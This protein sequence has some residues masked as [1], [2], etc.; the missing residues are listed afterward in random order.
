MVPLRRGGSVR[1]SKRGALE[2]MSV[3]SLSPS[4]SLSRLS[5]AHTHT[6]IHT[7]NRLIDGELCSLRYE[8]PV[9]VSVSQVIPH[10]PSPSV[11]GPAGL[12]GPGP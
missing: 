4:G 1:M 7:T 3:V 11:R 5:A 9:Q 8:E 12:S 2:Q 6:H 10:Q